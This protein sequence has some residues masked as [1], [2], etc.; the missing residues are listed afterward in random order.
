VAE[1][2]AAPAAAGTPTAE[3]SQRIVRFASIFYGI[4]ALFSLGYALFSGSAGV[5]F[6]DNWPS[7][8]GVMGGV[9][10]G[11][12]I[13]GLAHIGRHMF[14][15]VDRAAT[16][17]SELL[18]PLTTR[19]AV[20]LALLSGT[21]EELLFRGALWPHLGLLGTSLL[22]GVVHVIPRRALIGYP[23]FA[24]GAG[25]LFGLLR[26]WTGNVIPPMI[27]H[28]LVNGTNLVWFQHRRKAPKP[29]A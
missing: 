8:A 20:L 16:A 28:V 4:A 13:V 29:A 5:L 19:G 3:R 12:G 18:G 27:A 15:S 9:L 11:L 14:P 17:L 23:L 24:V 21:A 6:G 2:P 7:G 26:E 1:P 25:L 22:F 10:M